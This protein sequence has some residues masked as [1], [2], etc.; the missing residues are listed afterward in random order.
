MINVE[1]HVYHDDPKI[2]HPDV[3]TRLASVGYYFLG[4]GLISAAVQHAPAGEGSPYG[5]LFMDPEQLKSKRETLS[6]DER[7]GIANTMLFLSFDGPS[8]PVSP[9][10]LSVSWDFAGG[11]PSVQ[12]AWQAASLTIAEKFWCPDD[13]TPRLAR[14]IALKNPSAAAVCGSFRTGIRSEWISQRFELPPSGESTFFVVY[15]LHESAPRLRCELA[16]AESFS[17]CRRGLWTDAAHVCFDTPELD[18]LFRTAA[19]QLPA[20]VSKAGRVDA[21]IWQYNREW[22][23]DQ[24]ILAHALLMCGHHETA[25]VILKRLLGDFISPEGSAVDSSEVRDTA[26]AEL[27][28]NGALLHALRAYALWTGDLELIRSNWDRIVRTAE[29]PLLPVFREAHSGLLANRRDFWERHAAHGIEPGM[30]LAYQVFVSVGLSAAAALARQLGRYAEAERWHAE[31]ERLKTAVLHHTT[32]ALVT[33]RGF[34][35]RRGIDGLIQKDIQPQ[36]GS[37]VPAGVGLARALPHPLNP[38]SSCVL[39]IVL[40]FVPADSGV[41]CATL[42]QMDALWNQGWEIGGYGR[43]HMDSD[44]DSPG[45]WP[46]PSI[47]IA[48]ACMENGDSSRVWRV[49]RWLA[50]LPQFPSGAFFEMYGDRSAPP[51]AQN[52]IVPWNWAEMIML[53]I[54]NILGFRPEENQIR[55]R[56]RLLPGMSAVRGSVRF[57]SC[58]IHFDLSADATVV[59]PEFI[60][61]GTTLMPEADGVS[62]SFTGRD[63]HIVGRVPEP[64]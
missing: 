64:C 47:Y 14:R 25:G 26:E 30:E 36:P 22:V 57:R 50:S 56:P 35:K 27:D 54:E 21:G 24:S 45:P 7:T 19:A 1:E 2:G 55:F 12:I 16:E 17:V 3:R 60:V 44:P 4:N 15:S 53:V 46:F 42:D 5:L 61:D 8:I 9:D 51:Y 18:H 32:H 52:G 20:V 41:A 6:F 39:P 58:R 59:Q 28:Q 13:S 43:Y 29:F 11:C 23:R 38:D 62:I 34:V 49:I 33:E 48:R 31:A 10:N 40:G 37:G 63:I